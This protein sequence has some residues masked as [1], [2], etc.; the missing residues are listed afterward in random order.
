MNLINFDFSNVNFD[1]TTPYDGT[2]LLK[3]IKK[4]NLL[5]F[6]KGLNTNGVGFRIVDDTSNS[7]YTIQ[8]VENFN[9]VNKTFTLIN[10]KINKGDEKAYINLI[11]L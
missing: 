9:F 5:C 2:A 1:G 3:L 7:S 6:F 10:V 4:E 11:N 8:F